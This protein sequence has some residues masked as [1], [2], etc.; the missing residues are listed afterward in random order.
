VVAKPYIADE[1]RHIGPNV[2]FLAEQEVY[3]PTKGQSLDTGQPLP[4]V[5]KVLCSIQTAQYGKYYTGLIL[6]QR[7]CNK[8]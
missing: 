2:H 1:A 4:P 7:G 3:L 6:R 8:L 5:K